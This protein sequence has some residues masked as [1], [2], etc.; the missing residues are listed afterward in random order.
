METITATLTAY[1]DAVKDWQINVLDRAVCD[2]RKKECETTAEQIDTEAT[3][4]LHQGI[5][6]FGAIHASFVAEEINVKQAA[7]SLV[8]LATVFRN[9]QI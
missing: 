7:L 8:A 6:Y 5:R 3:T 2:H 4:L 1:A 9:V